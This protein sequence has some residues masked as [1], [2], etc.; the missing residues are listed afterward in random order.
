MPG[1]ELTLEEADNLGDRFHL[2]AYS[3]DKRPALDRAKGFTEDVGGELY[4]QVDTED[5]L[6][7][8]KG[9]HIVNHTGVYAVLQEE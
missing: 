3:I 2:F 5:G 8:L 4:T 6:R 7:Y 1:D 9:I